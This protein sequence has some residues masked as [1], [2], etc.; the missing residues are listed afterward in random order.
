[1]LKIAVVA[2][3]YELSCKAL[4]VIAENDNSI[5]KVIRKD[6]IIMKDETQYIALPTYNHARG[7]CFDQLIIVDDSR[8]EVYG[9]QYELIDW[10]KYR[11][12]CASYVPEEF[13][14]LEYEW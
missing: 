8:W 6:N 14:I 2:F 13:Q 4:R 11:L 1:M 7:H 12:S 10:I 9:K 3:D 5:P